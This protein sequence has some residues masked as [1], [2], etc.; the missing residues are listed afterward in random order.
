MLYLQRLNWSRRESSG[1]KTL[2]AS[3]CNSNPLKSQSCPRTAAE[4]ECKQLKDEFNIQRVHSTCTLVPLENSICFLNSL[5]K[6]LGVPTLVSHCVGVLLHLTCGRSHGSRRRQNQN[7]REHNFITTLDC[8]FF[9]S[10]YWCPHPVYYPYGLEEF[11]DTCWAL[12]NTKPTHTSL[13]FLLF[14]VFFEFGAK[15]RIS[16]NINMLQHNTLIFRE[17]YQTFSSLTSGKTDV[18]FWGPDTC[19]TVILLPGALFPAPAKQYLLNPFEI[20]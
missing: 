13:P 3:S 5:L 11:H 20:L 4:Y 17:E 8:G 18:L 14:L 15:C 6:C 12:S 1:G 2:C 7:R 10:Q 16:I 19:E 9:F